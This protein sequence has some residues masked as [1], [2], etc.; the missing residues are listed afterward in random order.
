MDES[1][2]AVD[3]KSGG[4][5]GVSPGI[6]LLST[7]VRGKDQLSADLRDEVVILALN[8]EE[9]YSLEAVGARIWEIIAEPMTLNNI[10]NLLLM[11]YDIDPVRCERDLLALVRKLADEGL[12]E[13][14]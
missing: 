13:V 1:R 12:I 9:Y 14:R 4:A 2:A 11:E 8:S 3:R 6:T 10:L 5:A 7:V